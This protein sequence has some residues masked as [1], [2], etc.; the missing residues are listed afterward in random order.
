M[1]RRNFRAFLFVVALGTIGLLAAAFA[2]DAKPAAPAASPESTAGHEYSGMYSFRK[3]GEFVQLT[4]EEGARVSGF[5]SRY[6]DGE[7]DKGQFLDQ[8]FKTGK[9]DGNKLSFTTQTVHGTWFSFDGTIERGAG[10]APGDEDYYALKGK[11]TENTTDAE[12]HASA[13]SQDVVL[14]RFPADLDS[15]RMPKD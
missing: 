12:K 4:I 1:P 6:G 15:A 8:F 14:K 7:S 5:V 11:L 3:E 13:K 9:L 2:Q 10:K